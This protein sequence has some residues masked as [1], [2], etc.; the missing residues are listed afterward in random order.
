MPIYGRGTNSRE[1]IFVKDHC[2]ALIKIFLK[3]KVGEFYNIGSNKNLNNLQVAREILINSNKIF[4][5]GNKVKIKLIKDRPGHDVRYA[6]NSNKIKKKLGW[7]PKI[8]FTK[9]LK[10]TINWY[11]KNMDYYNSIKKIDIHKRLGTK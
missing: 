8:N 6:L 4:K 1:W 9:G 11:L 7:K 2:E 3:G 10:L 5:I